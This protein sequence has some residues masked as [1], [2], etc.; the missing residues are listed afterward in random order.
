MNTSDARTL[1]PVAQEDLRRKA[2]LAVRTGKTQGEVARLFGVARP[3]VNKWCRQHALGGA[4]ALASRRRGR[5]PGKALPASQA[6]RVRRLITDRYPEQLKLPFAL[7][8]RE[9]VQQL[10]AAECG[11]TVSIWTVGRYLRDWGFTPQKPARRAL[12]QDPVAVQRWLREEYPAIVAQAKRENAEI[13][14]EDEMGLRSDHAVGRSFAPRGCT[15]TIVMTGQRFGCNVISAI[16]NRGRLNFRV[17]RG[18]FVTKTYL[19]FLKRLVRQAPRKPF[20]ITDGHPVHKAAAVKRWLERNA[21]RIR[22]F[23]LPAYSPQ[24][25][26]DEYLNQDVK[27]NAVGSRRATHVAELVDNVRGYLAG[28]QRSPQIVRNYFHAEPVRYA[29]A[30]DA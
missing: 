17:F 24:L 28:T 19:D 1:P 23:L 4:R 27:S 12:E 16:T 14:W 18:R 29:A 25:N 22:Q 7:W 15:P 26:P 10:I 13:Y 21:D 3:T 2:V 30:A 9:A 20:V 6:A 8:T 11:L 5:R